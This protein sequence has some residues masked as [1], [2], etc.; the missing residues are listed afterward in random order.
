MIRE[1]RT[2]GIL[3]LGICLLAGAVLAAA[4]HCSD[5]TPNYLIRIDHTGSLVNWAAGQLEVVGQGFVL[6]AGSA[7]RQ[8][9]HATAYT[10][11]LNE[12]RRAVAELR[13][14]E[15][16]ILAAL[17]A[18]KKARRTAGDM[19]ANITILAELWD[20]TRG[21]YTI[22]GAIPLY[23]KT[24]ATSLGAQALVGRK[25]LE[26]V[27][28]QVTITAPPPRGHTPQ[29]F[30]APYT[31][32]IVNGDAALLSPCLFPHLIRFDGKELWGPAKLTGADLINGPVR[33]APNLATAVQQAL[34]GTRPLVVT[35]IGNGL[36]YHPIINLDDVYM[37]LT[38]QKDSHVLDQLP[39][40]ITLGEK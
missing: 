19:I 32:I 14:N 13:V 3:C 4:E 28:E 36:N 39:I 37:V 33:Y 18:D 29:H 11:L 25:A 1:L 40:V 5:A 31:G 38:L 8:Q 20:E 24:G 21:A 9:A 15:T 26:L 23:G 30:E 22:V 2:F 7:A 10:I 16:T 12:A 35:A 27:N 6:G 17:M 34:A